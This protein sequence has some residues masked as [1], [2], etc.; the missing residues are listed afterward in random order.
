MT[1]YP[2]HPPSG[3]RLLLFAAGEFVC[4]CAA[5]LGQMIREVFWVDQWGS[6][7]PKEK[8]QAIGPCACVLVL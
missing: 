7:L 5:L 4:E 6:W 2:I 3:G 8:N 1:R